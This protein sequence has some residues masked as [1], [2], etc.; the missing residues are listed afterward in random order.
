MASRVEAGRYPEAAAAARRLLGIFGPDRFR[1]ELQRPFWRHD[2]PRN[3]LLAEL[4]ERLGV[5]AVATGN[6]HVHARERIALQDAFVAVRLGT[7]LD[8]TEPPAA[9]QLLARA[10]AAR[11]RWPSASASTRTRSR[12]RAARRAA[13]FDLT[14]DLGYRYPGAEDPDADRKLA[15]LCARADSTTRYAGR[16]EPRARP[17]PGSTRSCA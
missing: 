4:A 15:E 6:V 5:P 9:R 12:R 8:E 16:R 3:R 11:A 17:P 2:R 7:T 10:R 13:A 14:E 1:I